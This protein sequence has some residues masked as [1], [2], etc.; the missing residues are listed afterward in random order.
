MK[1]AVLVL[2]LLALGCGQGPAGPMGF[3]GTNGSSC[4]TATVTSS[5]VTPNGGA[6]IQCTDDTQS[7]ILNGANG[8]PGTFAQIV[9]FCPGVTTYPSTFAE[10]GFCINGNIYAVYSA[11]GGF[12]SEDPV[13]YYGSDGVNASCNFTI[14]ANCQIQN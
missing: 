9:Q 12:L 13:G 14:L 5:V 4:S 8:A 3:S 2:S 1:F 11:N 6:L 7:L 10:V